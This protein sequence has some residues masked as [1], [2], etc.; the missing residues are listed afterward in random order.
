MV[1]GYHAHHL[2]PRPHET[3]YGKQEQQRDP[4]QAA[5]HA[6]DTG[7]EGE[8]RFRRYLGDGHIGSDDPRGKIPSRPALVVCEQL[9]V[10]Q[11]TSP[12]GHIVAC[13]F[14]ERLMTQEAKTLQV[15][16]WRRETQATVHFVTVDEFLEVVE[17][18]LELE[19]P[20]MPSPPLWSFTSLI[21]GRAPGTLWCGFGQTAQDMAELGAWGPVDHCCRL[22]DLCPVQLP[23]YV[24]YRGAINTTPKPMSHCRCDLQFS[25]C[26]SKIKNRA[27]TIVFHTYFNLLFRGGFCATVQPRTP[28]IGFSRAFGNLWTQIATLLRS[29][30]GFRKHKRARRKRT[31]NASITTLTS[32]H[33]PSTTAT[34]RMSIIQPPQT[35]QFSS[36]FSYSFQTVDITSIVQRTTPKTTQEPESPSPPLELTTDTCIL[37][38][39]TPHLSADITK[40]SIHTTPS[41]SSQ[42]PPLHHIRQPNETPLQSE[43]TL[44]KN[45]Q[46]SDFPWHEQGTKRTS[47]KRPGVSSILIHDNLTL[48]IMSFRKYLEEMAAEMEEMEK[49]EEGKEIA[50]E[51]EEEE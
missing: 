14:S 35:T 22:H 6:E 50:E 10:L 38:H 24:Y 1:W 47:E 51:E 25:V 26:L 37:H 29:W 16:R 30:T 15:A 5:L 18:C 19:V 11:H 2:Y 40:E 43:N 46:E 13:T 32:S 12:E 45:V 42:T 33:H 27:A 28:R 23:S 48:L 3:H 49:E 20:P 36:S 31:T 17:E 41:S 9:L 34:P 39:L 21:Q 44:E 8:K 4:A 7:S